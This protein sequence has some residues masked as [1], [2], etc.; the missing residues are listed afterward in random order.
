MRILKSFLLWSVSLGLLASIALVAFVA[1]II[2]NNAQDL[3]DHEQLKEYKPSIITRLYAGDGRLMEEYAREKRIFA[4]ITQIPEMV[5]N[6]F[7]AVEDKNFYEHEGVDPTAILRAAVIYAQYKMGKDVDVVGGS[8]ITQQVVKNFL[9]TNE[10]S[11]ERKI[12]EAILAH[13]M[14]TALTKDQILELYLNQIYLGGGAYGVT[15]AGLHYFDKPLEDLSVAEAAYLAALPKAPNNYHPENNK[16]AA[17]ARRDYVISRMEEEGFIDNEAYETAVLQ[18]LKTVEQDNSDSVSAPYFA[19]EVRRELANKYGAD[20]LYGG[21]L[22][23]HTSVNPIL[24]SYAEDA[25]RDGLMA[26]DK[27]HGWRGAMASFD[28]NGDLADKIKD[29]DQTGDIISDWDVAVVTETSPSSASLRLK[30]GS[31]GTLAL[32]NAKWTGKQSI[33]NFLNVGDVIAVEKIADQDD[34]Y[35]LQ[36]VPK[37]RGAIMAIDPN[38]GRVLAMNGG[39][40]Y[41]ADQFNRAT[42]AMRQ[43]GSAFKPFVYL[44]ALEKGFTPATLI[45]DAPFTIEDR[46]GHFW[47]PKNY[48]EEY[49]GPTPLRK[50]VEKSRNLMTVRLANYV[51]ME[52]IV[53]T[54]KRF[55]ISDNMPENLSNSLGA[56][57]TTLFNMTS[58]YAMLVNGGKKLTPTFID[59]IQ[60]RYGNTILKH[61]DRP[62]IGCGKL[63]KWENQETPNIPDTREQIANPLTTYQIVSIMEGVVKRGTGV[64]LNALGH[65]LAG[66]TGT[67][68]NSKDAWFVGFSSDLVVGVYIGFDDP[69][70]LGKKETGSS[71]ALPVFK[72]FMEQALKNTTPMPFRTPK[73]IKQVR[74][75]AEDGTRADAG[76]AKV[77]WEVF[78]PGTE[79][80]ENV[81]LLDGNGQIRRLPASLYRD[82]Y[83][84]MT[85]SYMR[86]SYGQNNSAYNG[87]RNTMTENESVAPTYTGT[88]GLY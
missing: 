56:A 81:Y 57:E 43:P 21:G 82:S 80:D 6:A 1:V 28:D 9:L 11:F 13:R 39:W 42:Q 38:T 20:I 35:K 87:G 24:Q 2:H 45:L 85:D 77:I 73:G 69:K 74:V 83:I 46:P 41:G 49:Y 27:R 33:S 30:S 63:I 65:P 19:E 5:K 3:P 47:S 53:E 72:T 34:A 50:G 75:D 7:I 64:S 70:P 51:G 26:Y 86:N 62:C 76:D 52:A 16:A 71:V 15:A 84:K 10:R 59:R 29:F 48:S 58:A 37:V 66:K 36:Q 79:P 18:P 31:R 25:L 8:T 40:Q 60:D 68:N 23:V 55:G 78:L 61:D 12:K 22:A 14:E 67:T 44:T 32:E 88:G 54:A 4:P 17:I